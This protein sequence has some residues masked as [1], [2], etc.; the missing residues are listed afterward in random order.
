MTA[1]TRSKLSLAFTIYNQ[2]RAEARRRGDA[3]KIAQMNRVLGNLV[4]DAY[5][6]ARARRPC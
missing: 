2:S 4:R 5:R 6:P 1:L 3:K